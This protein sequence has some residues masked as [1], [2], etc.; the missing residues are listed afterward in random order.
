VPAANYTAVPF[1]CPYYLWRRLSF[2]FRTADW[3]RVRANLA[4]RRRLAQ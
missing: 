1:P 3:G 4:A 2:F